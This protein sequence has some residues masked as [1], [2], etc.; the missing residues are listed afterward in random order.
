M[1]HLSS[2]IREGLQNGDLVYY[3][4]RACRLCVTH[5][6]WK[7]VSLESDVLHVALAHDADGERVRRLV[8]EWFVR[9]AREDLPHCFAEVLARHGWRL[10][11][12][13][14]PLV[15]RAPDRPLGL[16]L[17]VRLMRSRWGS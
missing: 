11:H 13:R 12:V 14:V 15:M 3:L 6:V 8:D 5:S 2:Q 10:R 1:D 17:T 16:R 4:G 7:R 9:R